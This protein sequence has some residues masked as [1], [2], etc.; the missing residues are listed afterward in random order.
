MLVDGNL[1]TRHNM[2]MCAL[3]LVCRMAAQAGVRQIKRWFI[4]TLREHIQY[5]Y[6]LGWTL[7]GTQ[8]SL[9]RG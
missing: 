2:S 9:A 6:R 5:V 8:V 1:N 7:M 4:N 3:H